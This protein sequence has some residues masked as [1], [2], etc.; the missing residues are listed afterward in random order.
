M[1]KGR[2]DMMM[3]ECMNDQSGGS[4]DNQNGG[5]DCD[6]QMKRETEMG[7]SELVI[8][9]EEGWIEKGA[10]LIQGGRDGHP[11][12]YQPEHPCSEK[13]LEDEAWFEGLDQNHLGL[14]MTVL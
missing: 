11:S 7:S 2:D 9:G 1:C 8:W 4:V 3:R 13:T 12:V 14:D 10:W 6:S 5:R